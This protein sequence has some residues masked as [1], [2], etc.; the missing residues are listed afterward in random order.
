MPLEARVEVVE[1]L[2]KKWS[3]LFFLKVI[4][5]RPHGRFLFVPK[6]KRWL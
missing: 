3:K 6:L 2:L 5:T 4:F 1:G